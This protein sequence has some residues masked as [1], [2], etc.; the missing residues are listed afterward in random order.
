VSL[1][2]RAFAASERRTAGEFGDSTPPPPGGSGIGGPVSE[3]AALQVLA[4][5]GSVRVL[6]GSLSTLPWKLLSSTDPAKRRELPLTPLLDQPYAEIQR[7]DWLKQYVTSMAL[8]GNFYGQVVQRDRDLYPSQIKPIHPDRAR[9]RRLPSGQVEYT[10]NGKAVPV[11]DVFHVR[12]LSVA[13]SLVGL[14][15]IECLRLSIHKAILQDQYGAAYF[16]NSSNP[17]GVIEVEDE[18]DDDET[19]ALAR[20]WKAAHRGVG[21]AHLPAVLTGGAKFNAISI[22]PK[23]SQFLESTQYSASAISGMI[24]GIPPHKLGIVDRSTSW[25]RG[26]E[27]QGRQFVTDTLGDYLAPLEEAM[28]R[29]APQRRYVRFDL[30][31]RLRG[32]LL[33][34]FQAYALGRGGGWMSP[35]DIQKKENEAPIPADKGGDEYLVPSGAVLVE[36]AFQSIK[37]GEAAATAQQAQSGGADA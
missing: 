36:Q 8:R 7:V 20:A 37:D 25:G 10:F 19:V 24:F 31:E 5:Y 21:N 35:N 15:P 29:I 6:A 12:N 30:S 11:D 9:V 32:D 17:E 2:R 23:D 13:G 22:N 34:R 16:A 28:T 14:N 27:E 4:V 33:Q 26:I 3:T 18:L 1:V